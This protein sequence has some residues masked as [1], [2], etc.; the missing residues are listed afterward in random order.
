[1]IFFHSC[2]SPAQ[3]V[4]ILCTDDTQHL[5]M[6]HYDRC[7]SE[8]FQCLDPLIPSLMSPAALDRCSP[9]TSKTLFVLVV[10][11]KHSN[12]PCGFVL[13]HPSPPLPVAPTVSLF[14]C[15]A[16]FCSAAASVSHRQPLSVINIKSHIGSV[17][18]C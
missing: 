7:V 8:L 13:V 4:T 15:T 2:T 1:M 14:T 6:C 5:P 18:V 12:S 11:W 9:L 16:A 3:L 10:W 17:V